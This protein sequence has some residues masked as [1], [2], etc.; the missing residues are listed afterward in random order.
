MSGRPGADCGELADGALDGVTL[1]AHAAPAEVVGLLASRL[2]DRGFD[3]PSAQ[4]VTASTRGLPADKSR[5]SC[6]PRGE[7]SLASQQSV[8]VCIHTQSAPLI[9]AN[10]GLFVR[11]G[12]DPEDPAWRFPEV[13]W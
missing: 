13:R 6:E 10:D 5:P 2:G 4:V 7:A 3:P 11:L 12:V 9:V 8:T 1:H